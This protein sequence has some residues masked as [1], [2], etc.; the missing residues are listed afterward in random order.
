MIEP[1]AEQ[2]AAP[3]ATPKLLRQFAVLWILFFGGMAA[4]EWWQ[5]DF[6]FGIVLATAAF[7]IGPLGIWRPDR[8]RPVFLGWM[9][10]AFPIG[11][12]VSKLILAAL[13]YLVFT[14]VALVFRALRR[15][16]LAL[17]ERSAESYWA[18][19]PGAHD[20]RRYLRQY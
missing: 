7:T 1:H 4:R 8:I 18:P 9:T 14:P 10:L 20:L 13:F 16:R 5:G 3:A 6:A 11:F 12:V 17:R 19:K 15:D 2:H